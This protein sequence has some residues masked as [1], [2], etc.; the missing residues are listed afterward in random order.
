LSAKA[1]P[2]D[3]SDFNLPGR[4]EESD[5]AYFGSPMQPVSAV[6]T[7]GEGEGPKSK[8]RALV[9]S[10]I[11]FAVIS[12]GFF[13]YYFL[14]QSDI[15]SQILDNA[16]FETM[17][18]KMVKHYGVGKFGSAHSH[19]ALA[20]FIDGDQLDFGMPQFQVQSKYI[21]FENDNPYQI[22]KHATN[23][24]L[25]MLFTSL[26]ME[27]ESNCIYLRFIAGASEKFCADENKSLTITVN[28]KPYSSIVRYEVK[29]DDRILI[30][31]G[32]L[33]SVSEQQKQLES[34]EIHDV[35]KKNQTVSD[36]NI[37]V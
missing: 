25:H 10:V 32:N 24:P 17:E 14:N 34:F 21:H 12:A 4:V 22:H 37:S 31:L 29:H 13:S 15:D 19:A 8:S 2:N 6:A 26:G 27:I 35:P 33:E 28:G 1:L 5:S 3:D 7:V 36:R 16:A 23:V 18:E 20:V 9:I 11:V 30:S